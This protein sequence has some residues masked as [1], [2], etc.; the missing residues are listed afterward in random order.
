MGLARRLPKG[1]D[2]A[3]DKSLENFQ[4]GTDEYRNLKLKYIACFRE[5]PSVVSNGVWLIGGEKPIIIG[6]GY[7]EQRQIVGKNYI[8]IDIDVSSFRS[9]RLVVGK[10]IDHSQKVVMEEMLVLEG[11]TPDELP[12]RP[13]AAWRNPKV[14]A[15]LILI[16]LDESILQDPA[17][18]PASPSPVASMPTASVHDM[19]IASPRNGPLPMA[20]D[21]ETTQTSL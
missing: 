18:K 5:A 12:E 21:P 6:K 20:P 8:E 14:D 13:L 16:D 15:D 11:Q 9:A 19:R 4:N 7:M 3:F 10:V 2:P 1:E 17:T